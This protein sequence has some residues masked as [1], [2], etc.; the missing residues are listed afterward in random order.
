M[1][2]Q[3]YQQGEHEI[4][5]ES[6]ESLEDAQNNNF[7]EGVYTRFYINNKLS[8]NYMAMIRFI[9]DEVKQNK[10]SPISTSKNLMEQRKEMF[11]K[12]S[13]EINQQLNK[14]KNQY[15]EIGIPKNIIDKVDNFAEKINSIGMRT[16][17]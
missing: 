10:N 6:A 14:I 11:Q 9:V 13:E 8:D 16:K 2:T 1:I 17:R 7:K 15:K 5:I 3:T 12:Q 4:K